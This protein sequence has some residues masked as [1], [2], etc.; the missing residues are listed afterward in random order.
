MKMKKM[1]FQL[2]FRWH[3][4]RVRYHQA[5]L[6]S[7]L[8]SQLKQKIQQKIIYHEMKLKNI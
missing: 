3:S 1:M 2:R 8:D 5:L 6:E 4:I 7:C